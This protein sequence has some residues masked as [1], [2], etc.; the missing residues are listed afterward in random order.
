MYCIVY[1]KHIASLLNRH[2]MVFDVIIVMGISIV[3]CAKVQFKTYT[4]HMI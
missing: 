4:P 3:Q 2:I 1:T